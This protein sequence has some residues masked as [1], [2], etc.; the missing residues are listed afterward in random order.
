MIALAHIEPPRTTDVSGVAEHILFG[1]HRSP[2]VAGLFKGNAPLVALADEPVFAAVS[3]P[4]KL[5]CSAD[6]DYRMTYGDFR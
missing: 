3:F 4:L 2:P 1:T 6:R 5:L